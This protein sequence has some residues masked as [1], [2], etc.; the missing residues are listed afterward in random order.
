MCTGGLDKLV[1]A[2][3]EVD[4]MRADLTEKKKVVDQ[5][6]QEVKELLETI[7]SNKEE[8]E[9]KQAEAQRRGKEV[10]LLCCVPATCS[11]SEAL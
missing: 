5:K 11:G 2:A 4:R 6:T 1:Q 3:E 8:E 9:A 10:R 7:T